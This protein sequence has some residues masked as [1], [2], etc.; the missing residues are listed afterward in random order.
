ML[1][2]EYAAYIRYDAYLHKVYHIKKS[3]S[4]LTANRQWCF[5]GVQHTW[6]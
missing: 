1:L 5:D 2:K 4:I 3:M 6:L